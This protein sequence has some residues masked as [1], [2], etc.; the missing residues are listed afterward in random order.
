[1]HGEVMIVGDRDDRLVSAG[2]SRS[3]TIIVDEVEQF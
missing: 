1:M 3:R 2:S